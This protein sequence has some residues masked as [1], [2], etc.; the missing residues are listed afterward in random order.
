M[1]IWDHTAI[2]DSRVGEYDNFVIRK[3]RVDLSSI[4]SAISEK[5]LQPLK[6]KIVKAITVRLE[7]SFSI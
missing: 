3:N 2:R 5:R 7:T 6:L 4:L 1:L